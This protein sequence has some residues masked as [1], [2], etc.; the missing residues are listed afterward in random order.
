MEEQVDR[1]S[2]TEGA[3]AVSGGTA[4]NLK[5]YIMFDVCFQPELKKVLSL[6][7]RSEP[8]LSD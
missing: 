2:L 5:Y 7:L 4:V 3:A 1:L 8:A 6:C